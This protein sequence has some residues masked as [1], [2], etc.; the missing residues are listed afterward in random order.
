LAYVVVFTTFLTYLLTIYGLKILSASLVGYYIFIQP[1]VAALIGIIIL[2]PKYTKIA[3]CLIFIHLFT[4]ILPLVFL[5]NMVWQSAFVPT[6]EGQYIIKNILI[7][8]V[9]IM[10]LSNVESESVNNLNNKQ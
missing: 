1:I 7:F 5:S 10:L 8:A 2:F 6:L 3:V 4:T 9:A